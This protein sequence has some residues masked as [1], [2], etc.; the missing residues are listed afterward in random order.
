MFSN[1]DI[2]VEYF[3]IGYLFSFRLEFLKKKQKKNLRKMYF[4]EKQIKVIKSQVYQK[5][6]FKRMKVRATTSLI[7]LSIFVYCALPHPHPHA[8]LR[9]K[10]D[11]LNRVESIKLHMAISINRL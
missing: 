6:Y 3:G 2:H 4:L 9:K 7:F 1:Q 5:E 11:N 8:S 10:S